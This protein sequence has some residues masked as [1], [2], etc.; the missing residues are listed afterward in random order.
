MSCSAYFQTSHGRGLSLALPFSRR[1]PWLPVPCWWPPSSDPPHNPER[2]SLRLHPR[3]GVCSSPARELEGGVGEAPTNLWGLRGQANPSPAPGSAP[4]ALPC[5]AYLSPWLEALH[6]KQSGAEECLFEHHLQP[7][8]HVHLGDS[9]CLPPTPTPALWV[10]GGQG[11]EPSQR[12]FL[13]PWPSR[14]TQHTPISSCT[15]GRGWAAPL[16]GLP[17]HLSGPSLAPSQ[18]PAGSPAPIPVFAPPTLQPHILAAP[19]SK[20]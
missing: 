3:L 17:P 9:G 15:E 11:G 12:D 7:N 8:S 1:L 20:V 14:R 10:S 2:A 4:R 18:G 13:K 19:E 6:T 5:S 16:G